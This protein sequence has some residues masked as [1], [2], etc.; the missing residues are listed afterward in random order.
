MATVPT[1]LALAIDDEFH[2][3]FA[4][5]AKLRAHQMLPPAYRGAL[6]QGSQPEVVLDQLRFS[7]THAASPPALFV[8]VPHSPG[9]VQKETASG[10]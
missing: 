9:P 6:K 3:V 5:V 1:R 2:I 4:G 8:D 7:F 10:E